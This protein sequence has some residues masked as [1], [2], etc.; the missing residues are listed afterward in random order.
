MKS[1][2]LIHWEEQGRIFGQFLLMVLVSLIA[3]IPAFL[4]GRMISHRFLE[5]FIG[6]TG[7]DLS[8]PQGLSLGDR[9]C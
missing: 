9:L 5:Q 7:L 8:I 3:L 4:I 6:Q 1:A 2:S